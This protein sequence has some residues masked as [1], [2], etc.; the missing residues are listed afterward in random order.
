MAAVNSLRLRGANPAR[1]LPIPLSP[2]APALAMRTVYWTRTRTARPGQV[3]YLAGL[4]CG[5][6]I[7][8]GTPPARKVP[9][10]CCQAVLS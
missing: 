2:P 8:S 5:H 9:C 10:R 1:S 3:R 4:A 7:E 6:V